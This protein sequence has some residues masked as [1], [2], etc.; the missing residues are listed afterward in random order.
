MLETILIAV[1]GTTIG[2]VVHSLNANVLTGNLS[3]RISGFLF[4]WD[5]F[6]ICGSEESQRLHSRGWEY[7]MG[8]CVKSHSDVPYL[9]DWQWILREYSLWSLWWYPTGKGTEDDWNGVPCQTLW[10]SAERWGFQPGNPAVCGMAITFK[11]IFSNMTSCSVRKRW[12]S[13]T[14]LRFLG[15][16]TIWSPSV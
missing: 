7:Y 3:W 14:L 6:P 2:I 16:T 8:I 4:R 5:V 10:L 1:V 13:Y 15:R 9:G 11:N 12:L